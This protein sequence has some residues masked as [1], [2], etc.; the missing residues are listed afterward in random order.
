MELT[1]PEALE[2]LREAKALLAGM[3]RRID[4]QAHTIR[5]LNHEVMVWRDKA[6][7]AATPPTPASAPTEEGE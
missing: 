7:M 5:V 3:Q 2:K 6:A 1:L 4:N